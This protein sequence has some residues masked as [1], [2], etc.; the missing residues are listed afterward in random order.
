MQV[1]PLGHRR[2]QSPWLLAPWLGLN[3]AVTLREAGTKYEERVQVALISS[4]EL[5]QAIPCLF[6][7]AG[8]STFSIWAEVLVTCN[9]NISTPYLV[10][11][12]I[13]SL[14]P[15]LES[16]LKAFSPPPWKKGA[17]FLENW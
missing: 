1:E 7:V 3:E 11:S 2:S 5:F 6:P 17:N 16:C 12:L 8:A 13:S 4:L 15:P 9:P 10:L 14:S